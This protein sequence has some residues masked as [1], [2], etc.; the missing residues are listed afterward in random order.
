[1]TLAL[2][3]KT[4][5]LQFCLPRFHYE[6]NQEEQLHQV[7]TTVPFNLMNIY[8]LWKMNPNNFGKL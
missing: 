3:M 5:L 4:A 7:C 1:M 2:S 8:E 6:T